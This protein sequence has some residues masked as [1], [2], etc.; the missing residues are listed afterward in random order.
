MVDQLMADL[1]QVR[2][3]SGQVAFTI[4]KPLPVERDKGELVVEV[5]P[6]LSTHELAVDGVLIEK[7]V[8]RVSFHS[9]G[10]YSDPPGFFIANGPNF[11]AGRLEA[12]LHP[13]DMTPIVLYNL[14][15]PVGEDMPGQIPDGLF[16]ADY[17]SASPMQTIGSWEDEIER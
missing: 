6:D 8:T 2:W 4:R 12:P 9:G 1:E 7:A 16:T 5:H 14:G 10:A 13:V 11:Q 3:K 15:L 17:N